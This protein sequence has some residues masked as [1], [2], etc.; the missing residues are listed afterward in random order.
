VTSILIGCRAERAREREA[1]VRAQAE[2]A[3][4]KEAALRAQIEQALARAESAERTAEE[5]AEVLQFLQ[6]VIRIR[7]GPKRTLHLL[8]PA[9]AIS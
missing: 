2:Q 8:G 7:Q 6:A 3:R 1:V 9:L 5:R 4:D